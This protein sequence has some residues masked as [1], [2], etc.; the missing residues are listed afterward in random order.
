MGDHSHIR[1]QAA[2]TARGTARTGLRAAALALLAARTLVPAPL[3]AAARA[4]PVRADVTVDTS[5]GFARIVFRFSDEIDADVRMANNII[6]ISF[7]SPVVV[8]I[9]RLPVNA[10]GYVG[11]AR[12]DPDR[13]AVRMALA[14][15]VRINSMMAAERLFVDLLPESWT[16]EPPALPQEV[17]EELAKRAREAEK[18]QRQQ[19]LLLRT[20]E[21]PLTPV[22]VAHQP[23]FSR[24]IFELPEL[25]G[26]TNE[27]SKDKLT[28][29]FDKMMKFDLSAAKS[30][31][32]PTVASIDTDT[33]EQTTSVTFTFIGKVDLRSFREDNNFVVDVMALDGR[34]NPIDLI[35]RAGPPRALRPT[36]EA[37]ERGPAQLADLEPPQ[38]VP[39]QAAAPTPAAAPTLVAA[40]APVPA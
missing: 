40:A 25:I 9:D 3:G 7:K 37:D 15:K 24:Y 34:P 26:V 23:T 39:P 11:A 35:R 6:V 13:M 36:A 16:A 22:R 38:T 18:K 28:L 4:E 27:R 31:L 5:K 1:T 32:P 30:P 19:A 17:V 29:V 20:R 21:I 8:P 2:E 33:G 10:L 14:R 12:S